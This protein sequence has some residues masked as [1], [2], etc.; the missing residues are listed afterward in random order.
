[1]GQHE[2]IAQALT[3]IS[4]H[5]RTDFVGSSILCDGTIRETALAPEMSV[6]DQ[7]AS[8]ALLIFVVRR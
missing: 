6:I 3:E 4:R 5:A 2:V 7:T 8:L 1:M